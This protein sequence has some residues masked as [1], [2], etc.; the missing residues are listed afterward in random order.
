MNEANKHAL[1]HYTHTHI[2][3][4][5]IQSCLFISDL[6]YSKPSSFKK[7]A[8]NLF[9]DARL[10]AVDRVINPLDNDLDGR[11][12]VST[13]TLIIFIGV[14]SNKHC[15]KYLNVTLLN[16]LFDKNFFMST[17]YRNHIYKNGKI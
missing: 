14:C 17:R 11:V 2:I 1:P 3:S 13:S 9:F 12:P 15:A 7:L 16:C 10:N 4:N 8:I 6:F 5:Q